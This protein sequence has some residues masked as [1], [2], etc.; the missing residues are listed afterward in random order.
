MRQG[1]V[2]IAGDSHTVALIGSRSEADYELFPV[3]G[4]DGVFGLHGRWP[5]T[6]KYWEGLSREARGRTIVLLWKGSDHN[7]SFLIEQPPPFDF[8]CR[9][10]P[11]LPLQHGA[12]ILPEALVRAKFEVLQ[13][14]LHE[15]LVL[16]NAAPQCRVVLAATPPPKGDDTELRR[17][18]AAEAYYCELLEHLG[19]A[20]GEVRL[21]HPTVRLKLWQTIQELYQEQA[22]R[23]G[24][25]FLPLPGI[26]QDEAG[27]L[28]REFWAPDATHANAAYG[29]VMRRHIAETLTSPRTVSARA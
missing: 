10:C 17:Y 4:Q 27:F 3:D 2:I 6:H 11:S 5:R 23:D 8:V 25:E 15:V 21:T 14:S 12:T 22:E 29:L 20:P 28:K 26:A 1:A 9:S 13:D 24:V 16:L 18:L 19:I 7:A